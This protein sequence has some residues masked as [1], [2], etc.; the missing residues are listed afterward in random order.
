MNCATEGCKNE[1]IPSGK[2]CDECTRIVWH[3]G[4][5]PVLIPEPRR[6]RWLGK[7]KELNAA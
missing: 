1:R 2:W 6:V 7:A 3:T 5:P 4:R